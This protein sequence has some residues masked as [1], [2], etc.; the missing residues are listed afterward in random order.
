MKV[1]ASVPAA[2]LVLAGSMLLAPPAQAASTQLVRFSVSGDFCPEY[3]VYGISHV[4]VN[5]DAG[6]HAS[7]NFANTTQNAPTSI[8]DVPAAGAMAR[9]T[10][11]YHCKVKVL[12]WFSP[13]DRQLA[14]GNRWVYG[15]GWQPDH[16][17]TPSG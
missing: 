15:S 1:G 8:Q 7:Q 14:K 4:D 11:T 5:G 13:S 16:I 6:M 10:V 9:V 2:V 3:G 17:I 12:W